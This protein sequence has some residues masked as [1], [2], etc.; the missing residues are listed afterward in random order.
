[1]K[2]A[3]LAAIEASPDV[4]L[5]DLGTAAQGVE[6]K[7]KPQ[8]A[9]LVELA[10]DAE[11]FTTPDGEPFADIPNAGHRETYPLR[12]RR[13]KDWLSHLFYAVEK[14][15]P[16]TNAMQDA[17]SV[18]EGRARFE[19]ATREVFVRVAP[20]DGL[21]FLDLGRPSWEAVEVSRDGWR[22]VADPPV[23]FHRPR[24]LLPLPAPIEGGNIGELWTILNI[25]GDERALVLAWL[26]MLLHRK[27]PYPILI[28]RGEQGSG[29]TSA[30]GVLKAILDPAKAA[31]RAEPREVRDLM[32]AAQ[33]ARLLAYDNLSSIPPWLSDALCR[34]STGG[35]F[36]V[37]ELYA[38]AAETLFEASRP[39]MINGI[40][41]VATRSDLIDRCIFVETKVI[42]E[43]A[44]RTKTDLDAAFEAMHP[45]ILG[46]LLTAAATALRNEARV[47]PGALPRMADFAVWA[48]AAEPSLGLAAGTVIGAF[49]RNRAEAHGIVLDASPVGVAVIRLAERHRS[50]QGTPDELLRALL[51]IADESARGA[52]PKN[53]KGLSD[54][55]RRIAPN[56]RAVGVNA[57]RP[58]RRGSSRQWV[59]QQESGGDSATGATGATKAPPAQRSSAVAGPSHA[60]AES[61]RPSHVP[62]QPSQPVAE[63]NAC[64]GPQTQAEGGAP[65]APSHPSH[66]IPLHSPAH[67]DE[68]SEGL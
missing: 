26:V 46:A 6:E 67:D 57:F 65:A 40:S 63:A 10:A 12:D 5:A 47:K 50:W 34:L 60:V 13:F 37:R 31:L 33:H 20:A 59:V 53:A 8:S 68:G 42:G 56:L 45:R 2:D 23:R 9:R 66:D 54:L 7:G 27:G 61:A 3:I 30:A 52:F 49:N 48:S 4:T 25:H 14:R 51:A 39:V 36:A 32:I 19:G 22:V 29:K 21:I 43:Q 58:E 28:L 24:G 55:L 64:D 35:G 62:S 38:D 17:L 1:M 11:F 18:L 16:S 44:R 15:T 41:D